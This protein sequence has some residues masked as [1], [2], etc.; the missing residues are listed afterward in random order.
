MF[1]LLCKIIYCVHK[2]FV[3]INIREMTEP[4]ACAVC[5]KEGRVSVYLISNGGK[6]FL[7]I[8][9][10]TST[11]CY[12]ITFYFCVTEYHLSIQNT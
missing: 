9:F 2:I 10:D 11:A 8:V 4:R 1:A 6:K 3:R 7:I 5:S 12:H